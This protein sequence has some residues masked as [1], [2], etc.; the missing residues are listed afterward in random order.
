MVYALV[1]A[2]RIVDTTTCRKPPCLAG[3]LLLWGLVFR[4]LVSIRSRCC[5][6]RTVASRNDVTAESAALQSS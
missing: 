3:R 2:A 5:A 4:V 1:N 6:N